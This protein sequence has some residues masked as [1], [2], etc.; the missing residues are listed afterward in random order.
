MNGNLA[1][2]NSSDR[3][4]SPG[5]PLVLEMF[6]IVL[7]GA[8]ATY[9]HFRLRIPL[10]TPGHHGLEFMAIIAFIRLSS[11]I[12][13]AGLLAM[14]GTGIMLLIPGVGQGTVLNSFSYLL[15]GLILDVIYNTNRKHI[16]ILLVISFASGIAYMFIPLSRLIVNLVSGYPY[17]AF[18]KHG[19]LYTI[20]SFFF[21]GMMGGILGYGLNSIRISF[22]HSKDK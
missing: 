9:L 14:M 11:E 18:V 22:N 12:K 19:V 2:K 5:I 8:L 10:N 1:Q 15:P 6:L 3:S 7:G 17:M 20:L 21:F 16:K 4:L 13:Y